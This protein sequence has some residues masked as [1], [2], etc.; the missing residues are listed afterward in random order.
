[1]TR[2]EQIPDELELL[3]SDMNG[4]PRGKSIAGTSWKDSYEPHMAEAIFFQ[5]ITG[6]YA[7]AFEEY[8]PNDGDILMKID[9]DTYRA[10][11]WKKGKVGQVICETLDQR[12]QPVAFDPRNVLKKILAAYQKLGL[13]PVI[14]P[15][16]EFYLLNP[17]TAENPALRPAVGEDGSGEF[18]GEAF[19]PDALDKYSRVIE[20]I[21]KMSAKAELDLAAVIHEM[22][23]AQVELN[24]AHGDVL[25]RMDHFFLLKRLI[26]GCAQKRGM[27]ASFMAKPIEG[28]PGNGLHAHCSLLDRDGNNVFALRRSK[29]P[30]DLKY[31]IGG[32]QQYLPSAF[33]LIA[34]NVNSYKRFV[35]DL[36]APINLEWGYDNRTTGFRVPYSDS[37][38]GRVENRVAGADANPYLMM[39][40]M[41]AC[42]LLGLKKQSKATRPFSGDAYDR[43]ADL[44]D[45]LGD[46]LKVLEECRE[47][48]D[49]LG[50]PFVE[51][52]CS[53]KRAEINHFSTSITPWEVGYLGSAL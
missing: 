32:L 4:V 41:L 14:A 21:R 29:A 50:R 33:A 40:A 51:V 24:V 30:D 52:F 46:A 47:L 38:A 8:A 53:V 27:L 34:P 45:N 25:S 15:E 13:Y 17:V 16:V 26:K 49:H 37:A 39:S 48:V 12:G 1:M 6:G 22:G 18:G 23:P 19:S 36:S 44:P 20:D 42:G 10:T 35:R 43:R 2:P 7:D 3:I 11:P 9:W 31:F 28:L 5:T